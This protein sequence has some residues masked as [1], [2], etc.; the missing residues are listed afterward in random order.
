VGQVPD[1]F[2]N[3]LFWLALAMTVALLVV[4]IVAKLLGG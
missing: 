1:W 4:A 3:A 2:V